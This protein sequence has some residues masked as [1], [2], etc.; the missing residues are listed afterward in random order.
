MSR[1]DALVSWVDARLPDSIFRADEDVRRRGRLVLLFSWALTALAPV[2]VSSDLKNGR[3]ANA[4]VI[5]S[6]VPFGFLAVPIFRKTKSLV[7]MGNYTTAVFG[8]VLIVRSLMTGGI[9]AFAPFW[10]SSLPVLSLLLAGRRS[11]ITWAAVNISFFVTVLVATHQ[12]V[13]WADSWTVAERQ[14][15]FVIA[16]SMLTVLMLTLSS[17]FEAAKEKMRSELRR[18]EGDIRRMLDIMG[19]GFITVA[20]DG[21]IVG[22]HSSVL[23]TWFGPPTTGTMLAD[24]LRPHDPRA[25]SWVQLAFESLADDLLPLELVLTQF[26]PRVI[27]GERRYSFEVKPIR[28]RSTGALTALVVVVTD[29]TA[30][31][32]RE[33]AAIEQREV[34]EVLDKALADRRSFLQ[35]FTE[36]ERLLEAI[37]EHGALRDIHTLKG[38]AALF[39][40]A[41]VANVCHEA[42]TETIDAGEVRARAEIVEKIAKAWASFA[43]RVRVLVSARTGTLEVA[44]DEIEALHRGLVSRAPHQE[45][46]ARVERW[47]LE[48]VRQPFERLAGQA[49]AIAV[50]LGKADPQVIIDDGQLAVRPGAW[51]PIWSVMAHVVRNAVDHGLETAA[52]REAA[53]KSPQ[54]TLRF[55]ARRRGPMIELSV[56]DDGRGINWPKVRDQAQAQGLPHETRADL[57]AALLKDGFS[58]ATE[59][60]EISGRGVGLAAVAALCRELGGDLRVEP[61][62]AS[63][64]TLVF[65][66]APVTQAKAA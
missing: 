35:F 63:C 24:Y 58:T 38:N 9:T 3:F 39:G 49:R 29:V 7:F 37:R 8:Y 31:L 5:L 66:E 61:D 59:V 6:A 57:V 47:L 45:L 20:A 2:F 4:L 44:V 64:F 48:P 65:P 42:E 51:A 56:S 14:K 26:P 40:A 17:L 21:S 19:Q 36:A 33:Q 10:M 52:E 1:W 43:R 16:N 50:R 22:P 30:E 41:T 28:A 32:Q 23:E 25:A 60:T 12:G 54:G 55:E 27:V 15:E 53:G 11:A 13:Q 46:D 62:A 34:L 18:R